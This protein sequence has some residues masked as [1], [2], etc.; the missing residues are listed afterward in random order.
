MSKG[1]GRVQRAILALIAANP[2]GAWTTEDLCRAAYPGVNRVEKKHRLSALR[3]LRTMAL[4]GMWMV[5]RLSRPG[6]EHCLLI[7][8]ALR[9]GG[10]REACASDLG[11][12]IAA[13]AAL[14]AE[15]AKGQ[16]PVVS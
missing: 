15:K 4:P 12:T 11:Q 14:E 9:N 5:R 2:N 16:P 10:D 6:V 8:V 3:A 13:I 1:P 7:G